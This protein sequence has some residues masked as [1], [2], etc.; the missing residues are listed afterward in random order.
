MRK[1]MMVMGHPLPTSGRS[2]IR[3]KRW[4]RSNSHPGFTLMELLIVSLLISVM[5][6]GIWTLL[7]SWTRISERGKVR[8]ERAQLI[9]SVTT[10][11]R[12]DVQAVTLRPT[13]DEPAQRRRSRSSSGASRVS[14]SGNPSGNPSGSMP[15]PRDASSAISRSGGSSTTG[16]GEN[17]ESELV[18]GS[19]WLM[20]DVL[21]V[22]NPF[23]LSVDEQD[24]FTLDEERSIV[25][26]PDLQRVVY[27]FRAPDE[28]DEALSDDATFGDDVEMLAMPGDSEPVLGLVRLELARERYGRLLSA[29]STETTAEQSATTMREAVMQI[30]DLVAGSGGDP[31]AS[32]GGSSVGSLNSMD[33]DVMAA[34]QEVRV[35][36]IPEVHWLEFRYFDGSAWRSSWNSKSEGRLPVAVELR[37]EL[38]E[39]ETTEDI[40]PDGDDTELVETDLDVND[41]D[42]DTDLVESE[43]ISLQDDLSSMSDEVV[44]EPFE[45]VLVFLGPEG[46]ATR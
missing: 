2:E 15:L 13:A 36:E 9:R 24:E 41:L 35:D 33:D 31:S 18:G 25:R 16:S 46:E 39:I 20:I 40:S 4:R 38:E 7:R 14:S 3:A 45:R 28:G 19:D 44:A 26:A 29:D 11:F 22:P 12:D 1:K 23:T 34:I 37:F 43:P 17:R 42:L 10:Q 21:Q 8:T 30:R 32:M 6:A 27:S 5:M